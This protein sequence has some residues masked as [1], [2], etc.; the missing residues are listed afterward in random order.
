MSLLKREQRLK[1]NNSNNQGKPVMKRVLVLLN[2]IAFAGLVFAQQPADYLMA[3]RAK[4]E[5]GRS[6]EAIAVLTDAL[7]K[8]RDFRFYVE[9]ANAYVATGDYKNAISDYQSAN[10]I[11][12][13]SGDYGLARIYALKGDAVNSLKLLENSINSM[14]RKSE[15]EI[16]L[17][18]AFSLIENTPAWRLFW[19]KER[20]SFVEKKISEIEYCVATLKNL[21]HNMRKPL[22]VFLRER[23]MKVLLSWQNFWKAIKPMRNT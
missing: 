9:R 15:K 7:T 11:E 3:A 12:T 14:Y 20:Y 22:S 6:G 1:N 16:M 10:T 4:E 2:S 13:F 17:D 23:L 5:T 21:N 19:K 18:A 8:I